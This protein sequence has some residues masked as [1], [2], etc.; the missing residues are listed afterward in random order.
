M[1]KNFEKIKDYLRSNTDNYPHDNYLKLEKENKGL[2][3]IGITGS[4]GKT[5]TLKIVHEYLKMIGRK[6]VLFASC[7]IDLPISNYDPNNEVEVA[8]Y[9][10]TSLINALNGAISYGADYLLLE[11]NERTLAKGYVKD[12][13]FDIRAL[14][15]IYSKHNTFEYS[16]EE[17]I[18][19]KK[20]FFKDIKE[21]EDTIC[22][23]GE[24]SRRY[25]DDLMS[26]NNKPKKI[27]TSRYTAKVFGVEESKVDYLLYSNNGNFDSLDGLKF[28][29]KNKSNDYKINTS[30]IMPH[31]ALNINMALA[32]IDS[33]NELKIEK[34]NELLKNIIILGRDE[35]IKEK[36]RTIIT[37]VTCTPHLEILKKYKERY[38]INN[39]ILITGSYGSGFS[40]WDSQYNSKEYEDYVNNSMKF[41]YKYIIKNVD[42]IYITSVDNG[43]INPK[44]LIDRQAEEVKNKVEYSAIIERKEAIKQAIDKS[45]TGDVILISG[46]GNRKIFCKS[47][48]EI[49]YYLDMDVAK[50]ELSK[51]KE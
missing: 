28:N 4:Y 47:E 7:G 17:Y 48:N 8:I 36:G 11:I 51:I 1:S 35:V 49:E 25:L 13:P 15:N 3:I 38:L 5:T 42:K 21:D 16:E 12:I 40:S 37:S 50:E 44:T 10:E 41:I 33:L 9:N 39:I 14:T 30:L 32:I 18:N 24:V 34:F 19:L 26:L 22:I 2:K 27:V 20:S 43:A 45:N 23:Y 6:S 46:R 31:N 29:I